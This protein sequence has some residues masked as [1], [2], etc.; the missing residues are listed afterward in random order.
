[1]GSRGPALASLLLLLAV[2]VGALVA[3]WWMA[4]R[5]ARRAGPGLRRRVQDYV[6]EVSPHR[7]LLTAPAR[8]ALELACAL[9]GFPGLG[10]LISGRVAVGL[11]LLVV[12]PAIV[13]AWHPAYLSL[14]GGLAAHPFA[15]VRYLP[16]VS[17]ASGT[18]LAA[19]EW[20]GRKARNREP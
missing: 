15:V 12:A 9:C 10:W 17:L 11:I 8:V 5:H 4:N 13:W 20:Q 2:G 19:C 7:A 1:M 16:V 18:A 14:T 3:G 6:G